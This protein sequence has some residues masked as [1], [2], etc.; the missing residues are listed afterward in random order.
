MVTMVTPSGEDL[1]LLLVTFSHSET[2][3]LPLVS[4]YRTNLVFLYNLKVFQ[5]IFNNTYA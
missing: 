5:Y 4:Q 1:R 2:S 3:T